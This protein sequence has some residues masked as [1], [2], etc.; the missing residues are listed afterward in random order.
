LPIDPKAIS[1]SANELIE[2]YGAHAVEAAQ[3]NVARADG[4]GDM[5]GKDIA[6]LILAEVERLY[7]AMADIHGSEGN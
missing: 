5:R 2:H 1:R 4:R 6:L 3:D 7:T